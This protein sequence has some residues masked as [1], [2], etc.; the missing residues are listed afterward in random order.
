M[1]MSEKIANARTKATNISVSQT[2]KTISRIIV[3][4][5]FKSEWDM[6]FSNLNAEWHRPYLECNSSLKKPR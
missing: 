3:S 5:S 6:A 4:C 1:W 2:S